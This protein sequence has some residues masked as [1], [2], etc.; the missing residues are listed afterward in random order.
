MDNYMIITSGASYLDIDA[1]ACCIALSELKNLLGHRAIAYSRASINASVSKSLRT[2]NNRILSQLPHDCDARNSDFIIVDISDPNYTDNIVLLDR[3]VEVYDHHTGFEEF[4]QKKIGPKAKIQ[5]IGAAATLIYCEWLQH[6]MLSRMSPDIAK[7]LL[8]GIL[9]NTLNLLSSNTTELDHQAKDV[10]CKI[11][12]VREDWYQQ[13]FSE[14]QVEI[15]YDLKASLLKDIK[16][17]RQND[18]LPTTI[19]QLAIW[20]TSKIRKKMYDIVSC[21]N[22]IAANWLV[23]IIDISRGCSYLVCNDDF[24]IQRIS[25]LFDINFVNHVARMPKMILRKEILKKAG[26][27]K[28]IQ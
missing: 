24:Y 11:A 7:L 10:L 13:Y 20:D 19:G 17:I 12:N 2:Y 9:D 14:V 18:K 21:F 3:I 22:D 4:W 27:Q 5:F 23:N 15:E 8:A 16:R 28:I 1:Y 26:Y 25:D 6:N